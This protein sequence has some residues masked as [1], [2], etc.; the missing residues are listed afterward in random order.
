MTTIS[1]NG[2]NTINLKMNNEKIEVFS[3]N[4]A[5]ISNDTTI[6]E[7]I[8]DIKNEMKNEQ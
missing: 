8:D 2:N 1:S 6:G 3:E 5:E 7:I 4:K